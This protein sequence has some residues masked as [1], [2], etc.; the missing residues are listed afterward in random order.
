MMIDVRPAEEPVERLL[1]HD[2]G[3]AVDVRRRLVEDQDPRVGQERP[4]IEISWRSPAESPGAAL[5]DDVVEAVVEPAAT[6][7]TPTAAA[8]A[9][10]SSSDA[11]GFAKRM[12]SAI[13]PLKRNGSWSTTPSWRR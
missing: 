1:D 8:V 3:R 6:R 13:V 12:L 4:A 2:L 11:S 10:T 5:P 9:S 7:S